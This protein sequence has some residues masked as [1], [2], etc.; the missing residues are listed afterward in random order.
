[1]ERATTRARLNNLR[2]KA[3]V[4]ALLL[5]PLWLVGQ[6]ARDSSWLTGLCFYIPSVVLVITFLG[7]GLI[8]A[9]GNQ[10]RNSLLAIALA[11][12]PLGFIGFVEN[13]FFR[14]LPPTAPDALR[15][16]HWNTGGALHR[17]GVQ[18]VLLAQHADLYVLSEI[19]ASQSVRKFTDALGPAYQAS[20]FGGMA[21]VGKGIVRPGGW[22]FR[23]NRAQVQSVVWEYAGHSA[24]LF[25]VDL[26]SDIFMPRAPLLEAILALVARD[27]PDL[28]VGD[29]NAPRRS[30]ALSALPVGYQH[31]YDTC[32][33]GFSYT[34]P[35]PLPM[36]AL[37]QCIH[38]SRVIP[39]RYTLLGSVQ[40][41]H[42]RQVFQFSL[43]RVERLKRLLERGE[44]R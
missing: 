3:F 16:V 15:L 38:S 31:A 32:G 33:T 43:P 30:R 34:W 11:L 17:N 36:Y 23:R 41:D 29:F 10:L 39:N 19:G 5:P 12:P 21:V 24:T 18:C 25:V 4:V 8:Y 1:M 9:M 13:R 14:P 7:F 44:I 35:V 26:P 42:C 28:V 37:D 40:S 22:I 27:R 2:D 20:V 6:S